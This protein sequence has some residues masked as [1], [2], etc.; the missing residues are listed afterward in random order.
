MCL[1]VSRWVGGKGNITGISYIGQHLRQSSLNIFLDKLYLNASERQLNIQDHSSDVCGRCHSVIMT[2]QS[3]CTRCLSNTQYS[4]HMAVA[5]LPACWLPVRT[6]LHPVSCFTSTPGI[7]SSCDDVKRVC[8]CP[9]YSPKNRGA[10]CHCLTFTPMHSKV[11]HVYHPTKNIFKLL[12]LCLICYCYYLTEALYYSVDTLRE[13]LITRQTCRL[14][15]TSIH[16]GSALKNKP[17]PKTE[18]QIHLQI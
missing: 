2:A 12:E 5:D 3:R 13:S 15:H 1:F 6:P 18:V 10:T 17:V 11:T 16:T 7:D 14:I 8:H 9:A 4:R